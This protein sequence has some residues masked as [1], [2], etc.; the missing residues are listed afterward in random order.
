[1]WRRCVRF[2]EHEDLPKELV[3][4]M[5]DDVW[6]D[7][8][9]R[10]RALTEEPAYEKSRDPRTLYWWHVANAIG[11]YVGKA[12]ARRMYKNKKILGLNAKIDKELKSQRGMQVSYSA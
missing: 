6:W 12:N 7:M 3:D 5:I 10:G 11:V 9:Y 8:A 4:E 2:S 1:M